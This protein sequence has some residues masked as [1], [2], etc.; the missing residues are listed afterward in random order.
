V[1][2]SRLSVIN[3]DE[4]KSTGAGISAVSQINRG[5][6]KYS[7]NAAFSPDGKRVVRPSEDHTAR[8]YIVDLDDC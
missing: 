7:F 4:E 8:V 6:T 2:Q 1:P 5:Q 3:E